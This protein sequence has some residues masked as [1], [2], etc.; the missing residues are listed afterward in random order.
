MENSI[1]ITNRLEV[2]KGYTTE[3]MQDELGAQIYHD[4]EVIGSDEAYE[5]CD[6]IDIFEDEGIGNVEELFIKCVTFLNSQ[7]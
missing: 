4:L 3:R 6:D 7:K 5:L 1:K 2:L